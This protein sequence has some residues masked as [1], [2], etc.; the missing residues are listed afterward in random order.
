MT[1][2]GMKAVCG[3]HVHFVAHA[4]AAKNAKCDSGMNLIA[5]Y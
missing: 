2:L 3:L 4:S 5:P 1:D